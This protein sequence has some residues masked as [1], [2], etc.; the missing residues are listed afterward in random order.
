M[1]NS[2]QLIVKTNT[3]NST[4]ARQYL[5]E[6]PMAIFIHYHNFFNENIHNMPKDEMRRNVPRESFLNS[7]TI[8]CLVDYIGKNSTSRN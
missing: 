4:F 6:K 2:P 5:G 1:Q 8:Y 7:G 3:K